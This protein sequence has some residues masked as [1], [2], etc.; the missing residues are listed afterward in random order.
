VEAIPPTEAVE[1]LPLEMPTQLMAP[2]VLP[3]VEAPAPE[4]PAAPPSV[5]FG[6]ARTGGRPLSPVATTAQ[7]RPEPPIRPPRETTRRGRP[8]PFLILLVGLLVLC[9]AFVVVQTVG[10]RLLEHR[11]QHDAKAEFQKAVGDPFAAPRNGRPIGLLTASR[12]GISD[13][14]VI[15]GIRSGD[16]ARGPGH[17]P[18]SPLP[19]QDGVVVIAGHRTTYGGVFRR[20][21]RFRPGDVITIR[22]ATGIYR[23]LIVEANVKLGRSSGTLRAPD[24]S[25]IQQAGGIPQ[26]ASRLL[27]FVTSNPPYRNQHRLVTVAVQT[28][29]TR[30]GSVTPS[31]RAVTAKPSLPV[32]RGEP[33]ESIIALLW[34]AAAALAAWATYWLARRRIPSAVAFVIGTPFVLALLYEACLTGGRVLTQTY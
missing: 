21:D 25:A 28:G 4:A 29:E 31:T 14:A 19:G 18:L 3:P 5:P 7:L 11:S 27:V 33:G 20:V 12:A 1:P 22:S 23:Y 30:L 13:T 32:F 24:A 2:V 9:V 8:R 15:Q 6:G 34:L 16:L 26:Q 10:T 17:D